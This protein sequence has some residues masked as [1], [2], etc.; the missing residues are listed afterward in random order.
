MRAEPVL[1]Y[2]NSGFEEDENNKDFKLNLEKSHRD[3]NNNSNFLG[4]ELKAQKERSLS[5]HQSLPVLNAKNLTKG[6]M[7]KSLFQ[8]RNATAMVK[9]TLKRR[10]EKAHKLIWLIIIIYVIILVCSMGI[11]LI[12]LPFAQKVYQMTAEDFMVSFETELKMQLIK[13][14]MQLIKLKF[15]QFI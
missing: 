9:T 5:L 15:Y 7:A 4:S 13:L 12:M 11:P 3:D 6:E 14:K 2:V 8:L 10:E 1:H